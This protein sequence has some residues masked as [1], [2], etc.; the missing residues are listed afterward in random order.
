MDIVYVYSKQR[1]AFGKDWRDFR[2]RKAES[3]VD[4]LPDQKAYAN[5]LIRNPSTVE[6][7]SAPESS[8]HE[9]R[10]PAQSQRGRWRERGRQRG[11]AAI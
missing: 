3:L 6:V 2:D 4:I 9:V 1:Q 7:Q 8:E 10:T 11:W 5:H